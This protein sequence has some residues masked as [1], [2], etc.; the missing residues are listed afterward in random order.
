MV[1]ATPGGICHPEMNELAMLLN[2][3]SGLGR[4][5]I[6]V[7]PGI[8]PDP[9]LFPSRLRPDLEFSTRSTAQVFY[10]LANGVEVPPE[11]LA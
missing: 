6:V 10:F 8:V 5:E 9:L 4:Y 7:A 3:Q 11:H 1:E 2:L